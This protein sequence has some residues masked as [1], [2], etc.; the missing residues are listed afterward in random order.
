VQDGGGALGAIDGEADLDRLRIGEDVIADPR[1]RQVRQDLF[2]GAEFLELGGVLRRHAQVTMAQHRALRGPGGARRVADD[3]R[4]VGAPLL[5]LVLEVR[6]VA[7]G[8]FAA[9]LLQLLERHQERLAVG[10]QTPCV[11]VDDRL[12]TRAARAD[13]QEL[14]DLLLVL[15]DREP[16]LGVV[17]DVRDLLFDP[18]L[19]ERDRHAAERLRAEHRPV[20]LRTVVT[21][22]GDLVAATEAEGREAK[23]DEAALLVVVAPRVGLPDAVVLL[24]NGDVLRPRP[25][26]VADEPR[27]GLRHVASGALH[28][29]GSRLLE[30]G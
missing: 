10:P 3:R 1:H 30:G 23:R 2:V 27:E 29:S 13:V 4:V 15:D 12:Q 17:E 14:V 11:V 28:G 8:E 26:V 5:E 24:A 18:V 25:R 21:D 20:E 22:D 16:R 6:R 19:V 7:D 9:V